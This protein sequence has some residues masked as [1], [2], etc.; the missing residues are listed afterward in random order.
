MRMTVCILCFVMMPLFAQSTS[1][2][3]DGRGWLNKGV[4]AYKGYKYQE[5]V[6]AFQRAADLIPNEVNPHLYLA[7]ALMIQYIPGVPS[8][9]NLD[10]VRGAES[11]LGAVLRLDPNNQAALMSLASLSYQEALGIQDS[12]QKSRKLDESAAWYERVLV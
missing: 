12:E 4:Q 8:P 9:Q 10:Y 1:Y 2:P 7:T 6:E 3:V 11:E 5:A